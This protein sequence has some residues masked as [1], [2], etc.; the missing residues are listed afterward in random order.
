MRYIA[1]ALT[2]LALT[3]PA[4][5]EMHTYEFTAAVSR[6]GNVNKLAFEQSTVG[7]QAGSLISMNDHIV[8]RFSYDS[9][10]KLERSSL[11]SPP[12]DPAS[13]DYFYHAA[14]ASPTEFF[15]FT[16]LPSGQTVSAGDPGAPARRVTLADGKVGTPNS[17][18]FLKIDSD[19]YDVS[20]GIGFSNATSTW[21]SNGTLPQQLS[22]ADL[23]DASVYHYFYRA[24]G[25][26]IMLSGVVTSLT[27]ITVTPVPEPGTWAMLLAGLTILGV[28]A[29][30]KRD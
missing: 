14:Y 5:A 9:S 24:D 6:I 27:D 1:T 16:I 11:D 20:F 3:V 18:D 28:S 15:T 2:A 10:A 21:I 22:L 23:T 29:H 30:R 19:G 25:N 26:R 17:T 4:K 12:Y 13:T 8:G 7:V